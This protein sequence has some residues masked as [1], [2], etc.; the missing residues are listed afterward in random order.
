MRTLVTGGTGFLGSAIVR[1]LLADGD[2]V[3]VIDNNWRGDPRRLQGVLDDIEL[4]EG[5][6]R[7]REA[8]VRAA[9][10]VDRVLHMASVNGTQFFYTRPEL[11][12]D[13]G[14]RGMLA[15]LDACRANGVG[16]LIVASSSEVYQTPPTVPTDE[17]APLVVPDILNPRYSYGGQKIASEL[18]AINYGRTG[19]SRVAIFRPHNVYGADMGWEHVVP[20]FSLRAAAAVAA[21]PKGP[22]RF[23]IQGD[24]TQTRA[25]IHVDDFTQGLA[26]VLAKAPHLAIVHI[27]NPEELT[28]G[29]VA[30]KIVG[31]FGRQAEFA[32]E[33]APAG[34]TPR[35]CPDIAK[36]RSYG[37]VPRVNFDNGI[38]PVVE[39][40]VRHRHLQP[41]SEHV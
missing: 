7:D 22:V 31:H 11:V 8:V 9:K 35:R 16:D 20:Q 30:R 36:L 37:F 39:W 2:S 29:E 5:D 19:F 15:V 38:G 17:A 23:P 25:F 6:V 13:V 32:H 41:A 40:Y 4:V 3:R 34:G 28:I 18:L 12:L 1:R 24:G 33:P 14:V 10:G 21:S 27:G 26:L